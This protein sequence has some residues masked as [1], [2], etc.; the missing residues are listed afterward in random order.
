MSKLQAE[1]ETER[2][3][4]R[5]LSAPNTPYGKLSDVGGKL[6]SAFREQEESKEQNGEGLSVSAR[7]GKFDSEEAQAEF[8]GL[9]DE[10]SSAVASFRSSSV[11]VA[12]A[13]FTSMVAQQDTSTLCSILFLVV[14]M[15]F[16]AYFGAQH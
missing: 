9:F 12:S 14:W 2:E 1:L 7:T 13:T 15:V 5:V 6:E 3:Q 16:L 8:L 10:L 11:P 4:V